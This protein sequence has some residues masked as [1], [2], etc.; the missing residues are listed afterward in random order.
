LQ[1]SRP[2]EPLYRLAFGIDG[3]AGQSA[4]SGS[5]AGSQWLVESFFQCLMT[6]QALSL[7]PFICKMP[8]FV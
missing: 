1:V 8:A 3:R 5:L 6:C 4:G 7:L 2:S